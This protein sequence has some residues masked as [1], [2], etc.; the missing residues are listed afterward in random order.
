MSLYSISN[1]FY[2]TNNY[3]IRQR[4]I[5]WGLFIS[6]NNGRHIFLIL[7][8]FIGKVKILCVLSKK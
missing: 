3:I 4:I 1:G 5:V 8:M 6:P 2:N 7:S